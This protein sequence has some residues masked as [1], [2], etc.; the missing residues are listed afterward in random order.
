[1]AA[2]GII[3]LSVALVQFKLDQVLT[4]MSRVTL[5]GILV[6]MSAG[7]KGESVFC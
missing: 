3:V 7:G 6:E 1:M 2:F 5:G 4:S